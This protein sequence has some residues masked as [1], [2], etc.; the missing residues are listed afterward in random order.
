MSGSGVPSRTMTPVT[1]RPRS[2]LLPGTTRPSF[3]SSAIADS[4]RTTRSETSPFLIR[5]RSEPAVPKFRLSLLP[6]SRSNS[7]PER[8]DHRLHGARSSLP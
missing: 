8:R 5:S 1:V 7:A 2:A 4:D 6:L 3:A